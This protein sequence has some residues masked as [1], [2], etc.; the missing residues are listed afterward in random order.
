MTKPHK[1]LEKRWFEKFGDKGKH[2]KQ[3]SYRNSCPDG[4]VFLNDGRVLVGD[5][6]RA[7]VSTIIKQLQ[8][9]RDLYCGE[10]MKKIYPKKEGV[11]HIY[12]R[13]HEKWYGVVAIEEKFFLELLRKAGLI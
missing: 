8:K 5:T 13:L 10:W 1:Q 2:I 11:P 7:K 9:V 4:V 3:Q 6:K 12:T